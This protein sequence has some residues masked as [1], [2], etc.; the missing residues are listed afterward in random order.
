M[1]ET[2]S[3]KR[4]RAGRKGGQRGGKAKVKKGFALQPKAKLRDI[5]RKYGR[6]KITHKFDGIEYEDM[7]DLGI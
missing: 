2:L 3:E 1:G 6:T 7:G 4:A 5:G